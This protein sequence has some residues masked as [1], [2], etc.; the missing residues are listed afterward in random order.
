MVLSLYIRNL[1]YG[2]GSSS[3]KPTSFKTIIIPKQV[4]T[5]IPILP[6]H[7]FWTLYYSKK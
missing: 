5:L 3:S 6:N 4:T 2:E 1:A 7:F